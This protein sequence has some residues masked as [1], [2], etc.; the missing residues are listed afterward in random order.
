MRVIEDH[1]VKGLPRLI[2]KKIP[3]IKG[4]FTLTKFT[5]VHPEIFIHAR[6]LEDFNG[7][8]PDGAHTAR[9]PTEERG[10]YKGFE[11]E[12]P[13]RITLIVTCIAGTYT[14]V[15]E[16]CGR[17]IPSVLFSLQLLP[18]IPLGSLPDNSTQLQFEDFTSNL[19]LADLGRVTEEDISYYKGELIFY[20]NGFIHVLITKRGGF[21]SGSASRPKL[22]TQKLPVV[23]KKQ[24]SRIKK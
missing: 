14:L 8:M 15:Q 16:I 13:G 6:K 2:K 17:L 5:G 21:R 18:K 1:L 23:K 11:E 12:R 3:V 24:I 20:I 7:I 4:P 19:H 10:T 22:K 9:R